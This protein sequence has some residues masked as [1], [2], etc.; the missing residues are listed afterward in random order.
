MLRSSSENLKKGGNIKFNILRNQNTKNNKTFHFKDYN[1]AKKLGYLLIIN[2]VTMLG[3]NCW[4]WKVFRCSD[5]L[6]FVI[7]S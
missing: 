7:C 2:T 1:T 6:H 5:R 3:P 4:N